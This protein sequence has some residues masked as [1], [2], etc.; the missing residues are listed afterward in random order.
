[1][2]TPSTA[3][4]F[5]PKSHRPEYAVHITAAFITVILYTIF[6]SSR[7]LC[8]FVLFGMEVLVHTVHHY[9]GIRG[10]TY[11]RHIPQLPKDLDT[12]LN[13]FD[14]SPIVQYYA[15][16]PRCGKL[17]SFEGPGCP[18]RCDNSSFGQTPCGAKLK[19]QVKVQLRW[20]DRPLKTFVYQS[21]AQWLGRMISRPGFEEMMDS[22]P[23]TASVKELAKDIWDAK[24]IHEVK[25]KDGK[26]YA[27]LPKDQLR[28][29][30]TMAIDWFNAHHSPEAKKKWSIGAIYMIILNL[31]AHIRYRPENICLVGIIPGPK[32]PSMEQMN[33]FLK[34]IVDEFVPFWT[35]GKWF[36]KTPKYDMGRLVWALILLVICDLDASRAISGFTHF[37]HRCFCS[38]CIQPLAEI[39]NFDRTSWIPRTGAAHKEQALAWLNAATPELRLQ[40]MNRYG[41]RYSILHRFDHYDPVRHTVIEP[42][43]NVMLGNLKR[44]CRHFFRMDVQV[45][46]GDGSNFIMPRPPSALELQQGKQVFA[47]GMNLLGKKTP[48]SKLSMAVLYALC[49]EFEAFNLIEGR[50]VLKKNLIDGLVAYVSLT[51]NS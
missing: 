50:L 38:R 47:T 31:P 28:V 42:A 22:I 7:A 45:Y 16:C 49:V 39:A 1:M 11:T 32:K 5:S 13:K 29:V 41:V 24:G 26:S 10:L 23:R 35:H 17:F 30:L 37:S 15:Q 20:M 14:I 19:T 46:G 34:P 21:P 25:W 51:Y 8:S 9:P 6:N 36:S 44:H 40:I 27:E 4:Y 12:V 48:L 2:L 18:D 43:H 33:H 3:R